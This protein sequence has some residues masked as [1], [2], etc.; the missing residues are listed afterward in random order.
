MTAER[1]AATKDTKLHSPNN[2][3]EEMKQKLHRNQWDYAMV[4]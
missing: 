2:E 1:D 3:V 4:G